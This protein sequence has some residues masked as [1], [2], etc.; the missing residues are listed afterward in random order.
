MDGFASCHPLTVPVLKELGVHNDQVL[1]GWGDAAAS[2]GTHSQV[3]TYQGTPYGPSVDLDYALASQEFV[4]RLWE[5]GFAAFV[6]DAASGWSGGEHIHMVC[7][8]LVDD[9]GNKHLPPICKVQ[10]EDITNNPPLTGLVGHRPLQG[11]YVPDADERDSLSAKYTAWWPDHATQVL[12]PEGYPVPCYPAL[13]QSRVTCEVRPF[14]ENW[15]ATVT[16]DE[17][18][19]GVSLKG[20]A[21]DLSLVG[22]HFDGRFWRA[23]VREL[24]QCLGMDVG[25]FGQANGAAV[26]TLK[27]AT[28]AGA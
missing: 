5:F 9:A 11:N 16:G 6:R 22:L 15:G 25:A 28:K 10:C 23:N 4:A 20:T 26:V 17:H 14:A 18:G 13:E 24:A 2:A 7:L 19:I 21:L 12:A 3:G 8:G 27:Y 1:Q